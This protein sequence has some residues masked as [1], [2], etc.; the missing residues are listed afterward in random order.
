MIK[1]IHSPEPRTSPSAGETIP[2]L[3][4][5]DHLDQKTFHER[6]EAMPQG[7]RAELIGGIVYIHRDRITRQH[8]RW[9][10]RLVQWFGYYEDDT[11]GVEAYLGATTIL[12]EHSEVQPDASLLLAR[13]GQTREVDDYIVGAPELVGEVASNAEAIELHAKKDDYQRSGAGEYIVMAL[14]E[15]C[16]IWFAR[17]GGL[18]E[19]MCPTSEGILR[20]EIFPG[21]WLDPAALLADDTRRLREVLG[22]GLVSPEHAAFVA[23][24]AQ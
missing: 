8:G 9:R 15:Q 6:Y 17:R 19:A 22:Q 13:G 18:F 2:P 24:L 10:P 23:K 12:D 3:E 4:N 5:G 20:S 11:P 21:L 16:I 14:R 7:T 1:P